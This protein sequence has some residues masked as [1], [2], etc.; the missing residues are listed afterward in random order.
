MG[1]KERELIVILFDFSLFS[2]NKEVND[3]SKV[4][5]G[6]ILRSQLSLS[7]TQEIELQIAFPLSSPIRN[8]GF[9]M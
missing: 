1:S 4:N 9:S 3:Q 8:K 5:G 7:L 2:M 6:R